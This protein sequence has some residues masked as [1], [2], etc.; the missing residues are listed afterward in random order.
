MRARR[1]W[2]SRLAGPRPLRRGQRLRSSPRTGSARRRARNKQREGWEVSGAAAGLRSVG[3]VDRS[4]ARG[5]DGIVPTNPAHLF[6]AEADL[7]AWRWVRQHVITP[8]GQKV[9]RIGLERR[10]AVWNAEGIELGSGGTGDRLLAGCEAS[11]EGHSQTQ[12]TG[13]VRL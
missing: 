6:R 5:V 7:D 3:P 4:P 9:L 12:H 10:R 1:S 13:H 2:G 11:Q 8:R